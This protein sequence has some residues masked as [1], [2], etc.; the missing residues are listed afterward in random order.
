MI[1]I[2]KTEGGK[3][4]QIH[5]SP[6]GKRQENT[7]WIALTDPTM[8]ELEQIARINQ[9]DIDDLK[10]ALDEEERSRIVVEDHYTMIVLDIPVTEIRNDKE[11]FHTIPFA[12]IRTS[13]VVITVCLEDTPVLTVFM[14][15]RVRDFDL[16]RPVKFIFQMLYHSYIYFLLIQ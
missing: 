10:S 1:R 7:V 16:N 13:D 11:Y 2:F 15:G 9:I 8:E 3:V 5:P 6:G 12:I 14:D 4:H